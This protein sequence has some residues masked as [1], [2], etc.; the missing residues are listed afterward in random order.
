MKK[1]DISQWKRN[2]YLTG[3]LLF[4]QTLEECLFNYSFE[5]YRMPSLNSHFLCYD[6]CRTAQDIGRKILLDGNFIPLSEEFEQMVKEDIY[7]KNSI[8]DDDTLLLFKDKN[9]KLFDTSEGDLQV[10]IKRYPEIAEYIIDICEANNN[11]LQTLLDLIVDNIFVENSDFKNFTIVY[12][13]TRMLITDLVNTGYSKEYLYSVVM[14]FF[15]NPSHYLKC[16]P[17]TI[18]EFLNCFTFEKFKYNVIFGINKKASFLFKKVDDF[19]VRRATPVEVKRLNLQRTD[20]CVTVI[21]RESIDEYSAFEDAFQYVNTIL[22][23][24]RVNQHESKLFVTPKAIVSK[25][26]EDGED[27]HSIIISSPV[28]PMKKKGNTTDLHALINDISLL[29]NIDPPAA[30]FRAISLHNGAIESKEIS[31]QLLNLW[32]VVEV[33][34]DTKRDNEDRINTICNVL[35]SVLNRSYVYSLVEQLYRDISTCS[36]ISV[37]QLLGN[38]SPNDLKLDETERLALLLSL[39]DYDSQLITL[40][41]SLV[42]YPLLLFRIDYYSK[43]VFVNSQTIYQF[44]LRHEKRVRWHIMRIYR[45]RNMIV[46]SGSYMPYRNLIIENLHYYVDALLD[47]LIEYYNLGITNHQSI[48]RD[49]SRQE[50]SYLLKLGF[51]PK[52]K[53]KQKVVQITLENALDIIFNCYSGNI[54]K[55]AIDKVVHSKLDKK[56]EQAMTLSEEENV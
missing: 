27:S 36:S 5:S 44:L 14:N 8:S 33:L 18:I 53:R 30:F 31:N 48:Y 23:L 38:V 43:H 1:R 21:V 25:L 20:D 3:M 35:C 32:T 28:N 7:I 9:G 45:N 29:N 46:H 56:Q 22:A 37:D 24:H 52:N 19:Q 15:Y 2:E 10:K 16:E 34:I 51:D 39:D 13:A 26:L 40:K 54:I 4:A 6:I 50:N 49:I 55:K 12:H 47:T 42:D 41:N 11:Y 17:K